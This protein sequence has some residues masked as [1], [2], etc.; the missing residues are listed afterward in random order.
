M[1]HYRDALV[2]RC[3][4]MRQVRE[5]RDARPVE[6]PKTKKIHP[7]QLRLLRYLDGRGVAVDETKLA[8]CVF[9]Q[10]LG[11]VA[12]HFL[13]LGTAGLIEHVLEGVRI[14]EKGRRAVEAAKD[15]H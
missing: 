15:T 11:N 4:T 12:N 7:S 5:E 1:R 6:K 10:G 9:R 2:I 8:D 3:R 14:T 13:A